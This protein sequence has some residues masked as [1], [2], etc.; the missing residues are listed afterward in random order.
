MKNKKVDYFAT[1]VEP[2][3]LWE[4]LSLSAKID[5]E[6]KTKK[7]LKL[8]VIKKKFPSINFFL[9]FVKSI[10]KLNI[11]FFKKFIN[12]RYKNCDIGFHA[13]AH[14]YGN[15]S[16]YS[17]QFK[18]YINILRSLILAGSII[19]TAYD[20]VKKVDAI[21]IDHPANINN[22]YFNIFC[23]KNK[24]IYTNCYPR[25][26]FCIDK[27]QN[28]NK[29][30]KNFLSARI[31]PSKKIIKQK[32]I[33]K[34]ENYMYKLVKNP[35]KYVTWMQN[36]KYKSINKIGFDYSKVEY[37]VYAHSFVDGP[38]DYGYDGF[39]NLIDWLKFTIDQLNKEKSYAI[40]KAH[41]NFYNKMFK[42]VGINDSRI[43]SEIKDKYNSD[44]IFFIDF[45]V[46]NFYLLNKIPKKT[47]LISHHGTALLEGTSMGFKS[48]CSKSTFWSPKFDISNQWSS[49]NEYKILLKSKWS[50]LKLI[51]NQKNFYDLTNQVFFNKYGINNELFWQKYIETNSKN[52]H[53]TDNIGIKRHKITENINPETKKNIFSKISKNIEQV[54]I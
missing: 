8:F 42:E 29:K 1:T 23:K 51:K 31:S 50:E 12:L 7:K 2:N 46:K 44:R 18:T 37:L 30:V 33:K 27:T 41:P 36:T 32:I 47:V 43:F 39:S 22:I 4:Y 11:F 10:L 35:N 38:L 40:I 49:I 24:I 26:F 5:A 19:E 3:K 17:S 6:K 54:V 21:F 25:G 34:N 20:L 48:I 9:F 28:K 15:F 53:K 52:K 16:V 14:T 45:P 13:A